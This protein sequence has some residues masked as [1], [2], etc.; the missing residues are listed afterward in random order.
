MLGHTKTS[1]VVSSLS[2]GLI[3]HI[4]DFLYKYAII[5]GGFATRVAASFSEVH[6]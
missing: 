3:K 4:R 2:L 1:D 5:L 6:G